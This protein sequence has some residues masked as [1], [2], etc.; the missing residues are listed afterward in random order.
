MEKFAFISVYDKDMIEEL[1]PAVDDAGY[2]IISLGGTADLIAGSGIPVILSNEFEET[3]I[4]P[5]ALLGLEEREQREIIGAH[6]AQRMSLG[7]RQLSDTNRV[8][9][10][11]VYINLMPP[12]AS[13]NEL[14][15]LGYKRD[16]GG[17]LMLEAALEGART[18]LTSPD[19]IPT[20]VQFLET[21]PYGYEATE[22]FRLMLAGEANEYLADYASRISAL[23]SFSITRI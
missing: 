18:V 21:G 19:Q 22:D 10:D 8:G 20:Y 14:G 16:K 7:Y 15:R 4:D 13:Y 2:S 9:I 17:V 11:L 12:A 23:G 3:D 6:L 1:A 5:E